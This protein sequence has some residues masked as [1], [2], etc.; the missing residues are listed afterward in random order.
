MTLLALTLDQHQTLLE[1]LDLA[2]SEM[3]YRA[4]EWFD[5]GPD[6]MEERTR[7]AQ[8]YRALRA[9]LTKINVTAPIESRQAGENGHSTEG[10][11]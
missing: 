9:A 7:R 4:V 10:T 2:T 3:E 11:R 5:D 8:A 6:V 1:A